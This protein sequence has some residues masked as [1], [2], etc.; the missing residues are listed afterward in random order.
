MSWFAEFVAVNAEDARH[1]LETQIHMPSG[2]KV[3]VAEMLD[4]LQW[5]G[6]R[7]MRLKT[8]GHVGP[9]GGTHQTEVS[10]LPLM[11]PPEMVANP[12]PPAPTQPPDAS[13]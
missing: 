3:A 13:E 4:A 7:I 8:T 2:A 1:G 9:D 11:L 6:A 12:V 10:F 5:P